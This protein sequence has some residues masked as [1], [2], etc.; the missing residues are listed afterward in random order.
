M[1]KTYV[2]T[3]WRN[4]K[5]NKAISIINVLGLAVG[6]TVC[7]IVYQYIEYELSYDKFN[8]NSEQLFRIERDPFCTIAPSFVPI[9]K[10]DFPEI[11][12]IARMTPPLDAIIKRGTVKFQ[13]NNIC[14]AEPEIF[15]VLTFNFIT[16]DPKTALDK[17]NV[18]ITKSIA[19]KYFGNENPIGKDLLADGELTFTVSAVIEDYPDNSHIECDFL[20]SYLSLRDPENKLENDYYLGSN[21]FTDNVVL[22]YAKLQKGTDAKELN[23]KIPAFIDRHIPA[24][25]NDQGLDVPASSHINFTLC[26]VDDIHL[27]SHK[28]NEV[29][30][31]S[32]INYIYLF[33]ALAILIIIIACINFFNLLTATIK[34]R[35]NETGIKKIFGIN[36]SG[37][38]LQFIIE[39]F[40]LISVSALIAIFLN[41][42]FR[43][44]LESFLDI[45][46][47]HT[48]S[49]YF[50]LIGLIV[51][52]TVATGYVPANYLNKL[53]LITMLKNNSSSY[54][55]KI[56]FRNI[57]VVFQFVAAIC[58]FIT[59]GVIYNQMKLVTTKNLGFNKENIILIPS[60]EQIVDNWYNIHQ[61]LLANPNIKEASL[62][63]NTIGS[64]LLDAPGLEFNKNGNWERWQGKIPHIR[65]DCNYF[66]TYGIK[67]IAGRD[68]NQDMASDQTS[69]FIL[70]ES[71]VKQLGITNYNDVIGIELRTGDR[72]GKVVGVVNDFN[73]ESLHNAIIPMV[74]YVDPNVVNTLSVKVTQTNINKTTNYIESILESYVTDYQ[75]TYSFFDDHL[76]YQYINEKK[77]MFLTGF[78]SLLAIAIAGLGLL[79]LSMFLIKKRIKEIGVRKVNGAKISE[80]IVLLNKDFVKWV[81]IAFIIATPIA[82]YALRLWLENFAYKTTLS[83]WIFALAG[84]LALGIALLTVSWQSWK[85][86][87]RNPVEALRYE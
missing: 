47:I 26:K 30:S 41:N 81:A 1:N 49:F 28:L 64:R 11:E 79:G 40:L 72:T 61:Q 45:N 23:S 25:K 63:K 51:L 27:H 77:M 35:Y 80:V 71:A 10:Q 2:K 85:A 9:M 82:W 55:G 87:T 15:N 86:A 74:C 8:K 73:Y 12:H 57:L 62:S 22:V 76:A 6:I 38:Y 44:S 19:E 18:V 34:N 70:N 65:T 60:T 83:W 20:C 78:A 53:N 21:N 84:L 68:F 17:G 75:F 37:I 48:P 56:N 46:F 52:L 59:T 3:A 29:K 50:A 13:E 66:K 43:P 54:S 4:I 14:F 39:S 42:L 67:I 24:D 31:N 69:S 58:L 33:S 36:K 5:K 16:G 7:L 32:D